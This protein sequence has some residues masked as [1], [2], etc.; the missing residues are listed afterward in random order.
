[1]TQPAHQP[2][3]MHH[4]RSKS[5]VSGLLSAKQRLASTIKTTMNT[6]E[7][8]A[9]KR[10]LAVRQLPSMAPVNVLDQLGATSTQGGP[11]LPFIHVRP[12]QQVA[13]AKM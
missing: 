12:S 2:F 11:S 6:N 7:L 8:S 9:N 3:R 1:M 5:E 4:T 13:I 10:N